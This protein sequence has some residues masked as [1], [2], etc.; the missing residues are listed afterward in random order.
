V[1][2]NRLVTQGSTGEGLDLLAATVLIGDLGIGNDLTLG[3]L[4]VMVLMIA[5]KGKFDG[6]MDACRYA[7][8][9]GLADYSREPPTLWPPLMRRW[10]SGKLLISEN[11]ITLDVIDDP[12]GVGLSS[13]MALSLDD[14][15]IADNQIEIASTQQYYFYATTAM[16]GSVRMCDNRF[17]ETWMRA[18]YSGLSVGLMN[19][20]TDNQATHCL[21]AASLLPNMLMFK[22]NLS[23]IEAFCEGACKSPL[24]R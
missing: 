21:R 12:F 17:A 10:A 1:A 6:D 4:L 16:G 7:R 18:G 19:T 23:L 20:T 13:V 11:Q 22:D 8:L 3:L 24:D 9:L 5:G 15:A 2:R 14:V